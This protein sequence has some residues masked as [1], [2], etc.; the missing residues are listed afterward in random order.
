MHP[1]TA[2]VLQQYS[3][4]Q[5]KF[6]EKLAEQK[7]G[8]PYKWAQ[9]LCGLDFVTCNPSSTF[10]S[11]E[12]T[13]ATVPEIIRK[14]RN[15]LQSRLMLYKQI[16][17]LES[18]NVDELNGPMD[19]IATARV[20]CTLVQ[21]LSKSWP[22]YSET[23]NITAKFIDAGDVTP[24]HLFY[25]AVIIRGSAKLECF[26]SISPNFPNDIPLWAVS[27]CWN[28]TRTAENNSDIRVS[29]E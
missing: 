17:A 25:C 5:T 28:G 8:K 20:S 15:R 6:F 22:E 3:L 27:L 19:S 9:N 18:K 26:V 10:V 29:N 2:Y 14:V 4:D 21:W 23:N 13:Q 24:D 1:K 16:N 7:L 11:H 12:L